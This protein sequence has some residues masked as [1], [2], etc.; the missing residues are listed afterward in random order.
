[1]LQERK[2]AINISGLC[3]KPYDLLIDPGLTKREQEILSNITLSDKIIALILHI[4]ERTVINHSVNIRRKTGCR[5][6]AELA[7]YAAQ[8]KI[9]N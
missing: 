5:S 6:K 2:L 3:N 8:T 7:D 4:S 9:V 1:M